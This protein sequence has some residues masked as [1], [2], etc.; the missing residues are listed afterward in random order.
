MSAFCRLPVLFRAA[1]GLLLC[2]AVSL[3]PSGGPGPGEVRI[4]THYCPP[5]I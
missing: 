5:S 2:R 4:L 3:P 1:L